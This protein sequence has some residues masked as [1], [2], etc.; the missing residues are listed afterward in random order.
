MAEIRPKNLRSMTK[1]STGEDIRKRVVSRV[2]D[3]LFDLLLQQPTSLLGVE[4]D[5]YWIERELKGTGNEG[6]F[7]FTEELVDVACDLEVAIDSL[8]L[9]SEAEASG[10]RRRR[11]RYEDFTVTAMMSHNWETGPNGSRVH[12]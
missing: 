6:D 5:V 4:D 11:R 9:N 8:L 10:R 7:E 12:K 3:K 2:A 1:E